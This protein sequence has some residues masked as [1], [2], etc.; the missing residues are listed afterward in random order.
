MKSINLAL[1]VMFLTG[2]LGLGSVAGAE[3]LLLKV[4]AAPASNY[5]HMK[6]PAIEEATLFTDKPV[7]K[8]ASTKDIVDFYGSCSHDPLGKEEVSRQIRQ[9]DDMRWNDRS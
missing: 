4:S 6:F 9:I 1:A 7:L 2:A 8:D 3:G 5:C